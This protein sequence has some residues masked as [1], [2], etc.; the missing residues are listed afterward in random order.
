MKTDD[1]FEALTD[2]DDKLIAAADPI[3]QNDGPMIVRPAPRKPLWKTLVPVAACLAVL[4]LGGAFGLRYL[5]ERPKAETSDDTNMSGYSSSSGNGESSNDTS[6]NKG[7]GLEEVKLSSDN[8]FGMEEFPRYDLKKTDNSVLLNGYEM[9]A[10]D[11]PIITADSIGAMYLYDVNG[12]GRRELCATV[13]INGVMRVEIVDLA[14]LAF[15]KS[16]AKWDMTCLKLDQKD[17]EKYL[18]LYNKN[19]DGDAIEEMTEELSL[20]SMMRILSNSVPI[21]IDEDGWFGLAEFPELEFYVKNDVLIMGDSSTNTMKKVVMSGIEFYLADLNGD[22][23]RELCS[24]QSLGSGIEQRFVQV[25]DIANNE[26]YL[27]GSKPY[28]DQPRLELENGELQFVTNEYGGD[29][30]ISRE[31]L[32]LKKLEKLPNNGKPRYEEVPLII[33]QKFTLPDYDGFTFTVDTSSPNYHD[34]IF[35]YGSNCV[36]N[37]VERVFLCDLDGDGKREIVMSCPFVGNGCIRVYGFMDNGEMGEAMY[38][39]DG[40]SWIA[41]N[42][43]DDLLYATQSNEPQPLKFS[44]TDL[45][46][47]FTSYSYEILGWDHIM[48]YDKILPWCARYTVMVDSG[49]LVIK[50]AGKTVFDSMG[51]DQLFSIRDEE[52]SSLT[53]VLKNKYD[54]T[55]GAIKLTEKSVVRYYFD[56]DISIKP[57]A[58]GLMLVNA[59]GTETP[60]ALPEQHDVLLG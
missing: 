46:P 18:K 26:T 16:P 36:Q 52:G 2:I 6:I 33:D 13:M 25:Y 53:F 27:R 11:M 32:D 57:T 21:K 54:G 24:W 48:Y 23:Y 41:T 59:D 15:Y 47:P 28:A 29:N 19:Q 34:F 4:G 20:D 51:L 17:G 9:N 43:T 22:G 40:G 37:A 35:K 45:V 44:K 39:E 3:G 56:R 60:F 49:A 42:G 31:P 8:R 12:D 30:V 10:V 1:I 50:N 14:N 58:K 38:F 5:G 55:I 7:L